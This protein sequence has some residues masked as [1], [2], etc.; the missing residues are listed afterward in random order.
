M[1][2]VSLATHLYPHIRRSGQRTLEVTVR[3]VLSD[4]QA[5]DEAVI[6]GFP[7]DL[8]AIAAQVAEAWPGHVLNASLNERG[9]LVRPARLEFDLPQGGRTQVAVREVFLGAAS[10]EDSPGAFPLEAV[11]ARGRSPLLDDALARLLAAEPDRARLA[12]GSTFERAYQRAADALRESES[13]VAHKALRLA[14]TLAGAFHG[15]AAKD[16]S[17]QWHAL[18]EIPAVDPFYVCAEFIGPDGIQRLPLPQVLPDAA[19]T[20]RS[21]ALS[22]ETHAMLDLLDLVVADKLAIVRQAGRAYLT[23]RREWLRQGRVDK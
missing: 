2:S 13:D 17:G 3:L 21:F 1:Q 16:R 15:L 4:E 22:R 9:T 10:I 12:R 18:S 7:T 20:H 6:A 5:S 14:R 8:R 19:G 23:R 11:N